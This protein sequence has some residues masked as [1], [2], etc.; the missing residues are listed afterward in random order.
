MKRFVLVILVLFSF[1]LLYAEQYAEGTVNISWIPEE[2]AF[3]RTG[4]SSVPA[5]NISDVPSLPVSFI[6]D[7]FNRNG[8]NLIGTNS[9][10]QYIYWQLYGW[11]KAFR[12]FVSATRLFND[13]HTASIPYLLELDGPGLIEN[14]NTEKSPSQYSDTVNQSDWNL[15][16][17]YNSTEGIA[18]NS[19]KL[20]A[21]VTIPSDIQTENYTGYIYLK[22]EV[23]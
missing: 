13:N 7:T 8:N 4:F 20:N 17:E 15:L 22:L 18:V 14:I 1:G 9:S 19:V 16:F 11:D 12:I 10:S 2:T 6:I 21:E 23:S 5:A 3:A